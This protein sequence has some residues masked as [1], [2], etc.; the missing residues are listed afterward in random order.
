MF[1]DCRDLLTLL[2]LSRISFHSRARK[3]ISSELKQLRRPKA[4]K[5]VDGFSLM[6]LLMN[7]RASMISIQ[8]TQRLVRASPRADHLVWERLFRT[9]E[10]GINFDTKIPHQC[11]EIVK[12]LYNACKLL[13]KDIS[14]S[15][16]SAAHDPTRFSEWAEQGIKTAKWFTSFIL[17]WRPE[18]APDML[19]ALSYDCPRQS[20]ISKS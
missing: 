18:Y 20:A 19:L 13:K 11:V 1:T 15:Q 12:N 5:R 6:S 16:H 4:S 14:D 17:A 10:F 2:N 3:H 8:E 7:L 9:V